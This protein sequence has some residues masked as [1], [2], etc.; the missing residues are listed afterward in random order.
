M[1]VSALQHE[2]NIKCLE[3]TFLVE[4]L[5]VSEKTKNNLYRLSKGQVDYQTLIRE[6]Q[7]KYIKKKV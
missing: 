2:K 6:V 3:G 5:S 1:G 4:G 7:N